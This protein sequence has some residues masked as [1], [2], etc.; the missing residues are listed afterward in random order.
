MLLTKYYFSRDVIVKYK[1]VC[2]E[3][4]LIVASFYMCRIIKA[5]PLVVGLFNGM[6]VISGRN[7]RNQKY[8]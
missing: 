1:K 7:I 3:R 4:F 6:A 5:L 8:G 2:H